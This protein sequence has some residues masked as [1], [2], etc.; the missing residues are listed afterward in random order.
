MTDKRLLQVFLSLQSDNPGPG[1]F[2]VSSDQEKKLLCTCPGFAA[3]N[4]CK[5]TALVEIRI[6]KNNGVYQFDFSKKVTPEELKKAMRTEESFRDLVI[7][8]GKV[9]VY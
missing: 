1:I 8:H 6:A 9:E 2:E 7:M 3:K 5:H 4:S